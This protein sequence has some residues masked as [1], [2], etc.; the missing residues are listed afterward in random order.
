MRRVAQNARTSITKKKK[1]FRQLIFSES[2][3]EQA[4]QKEE[5]E[6]NSDIEDA[7]PKEVFEAMSKLATGY[8]PTTEF[9]DVYCCCFDCGVEGTYDEVNDHEIICNLRHYN[10]EIVGKW[11][12]MI[13]KMRDFQSDQ[14]FDMQKYV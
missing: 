7:T 11:N 3:E 9:K 2:E 5:P 1:K 10:M 4:P 12:T 6:D 8:R 14:I 13:R